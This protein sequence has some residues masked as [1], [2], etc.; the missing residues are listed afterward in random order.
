MTTAVFRKDR[1]H[2]L[3]ER[4]LRKATAADGTIA[5][6]ILCELVSATYKE[7]DSRARLDR[8]AQDILQEQLEAANARGREEAEA[9]FVVVM[10][11]VGEAVVVIDERGLIEE[12]NK[13]AERTFGFE[14]REVIGRNVSML[15]TAPDAAHHDATLQTYLH[16]GERHIIGKGRE[17][18][19]RRKNGEEFPIDLAVGEV[20]SGGR[21]RFLGVLREITQRK[22]L[23]RELRE[24]AARFR[25]MTSSASD[26]FWE[27][28]ADYRLTFASDRISSVLGVKPSAILGNSFFD[29]GLGDGDPALAEAHRACIADRL[30]FRDIVFLVG[31]EEGK[32]AKAIRINGTP[33]HDENGKFL[34]YRG[35]GVDIT[36]ETAEQ[37]AKLA[38]QQLADALESVGDAIAVFD[39]DDKL[40]VCNQ[41]YKTIFGDIKHRVRPGVSF[42]DILDLLMSRQ[43]FDTD[44]ISQEEW[45]QHR[46]RLHREASGEPFILRTAGHWILSREYRTSDGGIIGVRTDITELK[47]REAELDTLRRRYQLI[48][49]FAGEGIV[50]LDENGDVIFANKMACEILCVQA[51]DLI[52][53]NFH[54]SVCP[55]STGQDMDKALREGIAEQVVGYTFQCFDGGTVYVDYQSAPIVKDGHAVGAVVVFRDAELRLRYEQ[56]LADQ[57]RELERLVAERTGELRREVDIRSKTEG[58]LRASRERLKTIAD[59]LFEGVLV[60]DREGHLISANASARSLLRTDPTAGDIEG[61]PLDTLML[62]QRSKGL[63]SFADSPWQHVL[64]DGITMRDDDAVFATADGTLL[65]VAYACS[66]LKEE[67]TVRGAII[68]FRD[69]QSLK[70]AQREALQSS[71]LATVGQ[72]AAGIAHE[73]NTP[74]QYLGDNLRFIGRSLGKLSGPVE[75][76]LT[77]GN[78]EFDAAAASVKLPFLLKELPVALDEALDGVAQIARI[79]LSMKEFSHPGSTSKSMTD[80]NRAIESTLTVSR[81]TWKHIAELHQDLDPS[82]PPVLCLAGEINQVFLNLFVNAAHAIEASGK[83][84]PGLLSVSTALV[85]DGVEI[86]VADTGTGVPEDIREHVFDPFF[87]TK[88]VGKGTGQGLAICRDVVVAKHGGRI[89]VGGEPGQGAVFTVWLPIAPDE[90]TDGGEP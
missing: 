72:L 69:I 74:I 30:P 34:G 5:V 59:S 87:T 43:A 53:R 7:V 65:S 66:P 1:M 63:L 83:P 77:L 58:A 80:I 57:Q 38:Q 36:R 16:T 71:R 81:N 41:H 35:I 82:L 76:A 14:A 62:L 47:Q 40:V 79:V 46:L 2:K 9:R 13:A 70:R 19:A 85:G 6:P 67:G 89:E 68:S 33:V 45:R 15:M 39:P 61:H 78:P 90:G 10:D 56:G 29:I 48:L 4:Q 37:R 86:R 54:S 20:V 84:L 32:D 17:V 22:L 75:V 49:D 28:D 55:T 44:G 42:E 50:G 12:F 26:W 73:I 3:L 8:Y 51:G 60:I 24:S 64:A 18:T 52:G 31:P 88:D 25:D 21:R 23:E 11:N 27:T